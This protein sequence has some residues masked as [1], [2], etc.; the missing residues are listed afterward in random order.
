[1]GATN[2]A[3]VA[4][5][6]KTGQVLAYVGS[7][8]YFNDA[9][10]GQVDNV[11]ALSQP[12]STIKPITYVT[13]FTK[14]WSPATIVT[15]EPIKLSTGTSSYTLGNADN[16]FRGSIPV[17][18]ALASSLN[19]PAVKALE[20]AG[21]ENVYANARRLGLTTLKDVSAYGP[22]FTLGGAD[23]TLLDLTYAFSTFA[24]YGEQAGMKSVLDLP[25]GS[26]PMDPVI[27]LKVA[28]A[29][30]HNV[31]QPKAGKERIV[32]A[33]QAYILTH[34][35]SDDNAR[36]SM[37]GTNSVLKIAGRETVVKS[38]LTDNARDAWTIGYSPELV[39]GVWV[40]NSNNTPMP[41]ATSTYAAAP[42]WHNFMERALQG[43]QAQSFSVP[44]GVKF[45]QVC[46]RT[47]LLPDR[48]CPKVVNEVFVSNRVPTSMGGGP[49]VQ[50][51][52]TSTPRPEPTARPARPTATPRIKEPEPTRRPTSTPRSS[53]ERSNPGRG[54]GNG[55]SNGNN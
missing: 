15:D 53:F 7:R 55:N 44:S 12:G 32:P 42:I 17:R 11:T 45:A 33:E 38:G 20:Y 31:W 23:V 29:K 2:A 9:I 43:K 48:S 14:G 26:R 4:M 37:F 8:D 18:T 1:V 16:R 34:V 40:G 22:A 25:D 50:T 36:A 5:D 13:A 19:P 49:R 30:G 10:S 35:L 27:V 54:P 47:G 21:L 39:T 28:D 3:L 52:G 41:G 24:N 6:P 46:E 51:Q